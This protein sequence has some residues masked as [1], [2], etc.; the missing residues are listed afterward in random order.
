MSSWFLRSS[1]YSLHEQQKDVVAV[2]ALQEETKFCLK[3]EK[4]FLS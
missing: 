4:Q 1:E 2:A 3:R